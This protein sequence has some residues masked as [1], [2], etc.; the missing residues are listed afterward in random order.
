MPSAEK[1]A[2]PISRVPAYIRFVCGAGMLFLSYLVDLNN[3]P[4]GVSYTEGFIVA[5]T[6]ATL[7]IVLCKSAFGW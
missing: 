2:N 7:G 3:L 6:G 5:L 1:P 4:V